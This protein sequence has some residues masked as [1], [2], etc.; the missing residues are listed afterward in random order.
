MTTHT[1][2]TENNRE[3]APK[4]TTQCGSVVQHI[5]VASHI[6]HE[7]FGSKFHRKLLA[8]TYAL[9]VARNVGK[10]RESLRACPRLCTLKFRESLRAC[11]RLC[12]L[13]F[14][15]CSRQ[16]V[17]DYLSGR[18]FR[19][20]LP[21]IKSQTRNKDPK[22]LESN[23]TAEQFQATTTV[24]QPTLYAAHTSRQSLS[25]N[26]QREANVKMSM[27][28]RDPLVREL[29]FDDYDRRYC[30]PARYHLPQ[31]VRV[32]R[33]LSDGW[34]SVQ[35][36]FDQALTDLQ[37]VMDNVNEAI[38]HY[39]SSLVKDLGTGGMKTTRG[40]DG[41]LQMAIDVSQYKPEEVNVKLCD[42]NLVVE[43]RTESSENDSYHKAEFKRW[44]RLPQDVKHEAIK[45]T[46]TPD[47][48]LLI[49]VPC[50]K[51]IQ[52]DRSRNI[53]IEVQK[54]PAQVEGD[55]AK[56]QSEGQQQSKVQKAA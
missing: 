53:P 11:L 23:S 26:S 38:G 30:R 49:E 45:S 56:G 16:L 55:K 25:V 6:H 20:P 2:F 41:T 50:H 21:D 51:P 36:S 32:H 52:S 22:R 1:I 34:P 43:A 7:E 40:E 12:T 28:L 33:L 42:D 29:L 14:R 47:K 54:A 31:P 15:E 3:I 4:V 13:K 35:P 24:I 9:D 48:K 8:N 17:L 10:F 19:L 39:Q 37:S 5:G 27:L 44:V 18:V 46:L